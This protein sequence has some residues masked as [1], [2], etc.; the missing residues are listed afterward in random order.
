MSMEIF[1]YLNNRLTKAFLLF[2][3]GHEYIYMKDDEKDFQEIKLSKTYK[4]KKVTLF[5][6]QVINGNKWNDTC[7]SEVKFY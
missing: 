3:D 7:I 2:D 5:I 6:Q 1:Y 4:T